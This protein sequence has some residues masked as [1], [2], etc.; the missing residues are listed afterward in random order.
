METNSL[1]VDEGEEVLEHESVVGFWVITGDSD[2][3]VLQVSVDPDGPAIRR[4]M[5]T[6]QEKRAV[7]KFPVC[8]SRLLTS[9]D[10][11]ADQL[12]SCILKPADSL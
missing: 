3:F 4:T 11:L 8:V 9:D 6:I 5:L 7:S 10:I 1:D 2:V 12:I